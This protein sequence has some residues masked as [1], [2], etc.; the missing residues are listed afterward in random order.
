LYKLVKSVCFALQGVLVVPSVPATGEEL[1][2]LGVGDEQQPV[3]PTIREF[4][5]DY[6]N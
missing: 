2:V 4:S 3:E 5:I 6:E 1:L